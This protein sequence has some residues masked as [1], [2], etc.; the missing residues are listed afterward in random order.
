MEVAAYVELCTRLSRFVQ[1]QP[2]DAQCKE[3][4]SVL[5][6]L[7]ALYDRVER[8]SPPQNLA[9]DASLVGFA[10]MDDLVLLSIHK[11]LGAFV[12][13][14]SSPVLQER[15]FAVFTRVLR[16]CKPRMQGNNAGH[17][18]R[19]LGFVQSCVLYL[20]PPPEASDGGEDVP[21][22]MKLAAQP[23][24][25]RLAILQSLREL[26]S[27]EDKGEEK[28]MQLQVD[29]QHFFA[30]VV[31]SLLHV[32]QKDRCREAALQAVGVLRVLKVATEHE[33]TK[34]H[35]ISR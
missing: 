6:E 30:Y 31:A 28:G 18:Q 20:P 4:Q 25:L 1:L 21:G 3:L 16:R 10:A 35:L 12:L 14:S 13:N 2:D 15:S 23:E 32:A 34:V 29:Q 8:S 19:R 9:V 5:D 27:E 22:S 26:L 17:V 24:E 7:L 33:A 11:L